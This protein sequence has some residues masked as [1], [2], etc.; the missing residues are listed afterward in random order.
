LC[1]PKQIRGRRALP[2]GRNYLPLRVNSAGVM[3]ILFASSTFVL[4]QVLGLIPGLEW[5]RVP[6]ERLGFV[7]T[8]VHTGAVF[9]FAY[10]WTFLFY[11]PSQIALQLQEAGSFIP[12]LRPGERTAR[13]LEGILSRLTLLGAAF[14][15]SVALLPALLGGWMGGGIPWDSFLGGTSLLIVVGVG[16]DLVAKLEA[17][18]NMHRYGGFLDRPKS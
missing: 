5:I 12:G 4:P 16:L 2:G 15:A 1:H 3:P 11:S 6:F 17:I 10:F 13:F 14:L 8:L 9:F 7:F 18:L